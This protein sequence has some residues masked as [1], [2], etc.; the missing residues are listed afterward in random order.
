MAR[1]TR[2]WMLSLI[3]LLV[4]TAITY[5]FWPKPMKVDIGQ[6]VQKPMLISIDEEAKTR[7]REAYVVSTP[8]AGRLLRVDIEPGDIVIGNQSVVARMLPTNPSA[9]DV[10]TT[11]QAN[12]A[13]SA[14][15]AALRLARADLNK[16]MIDR[17]LVEQE[18]ER[19]K[20]LFES[21]VI[22]QVALD[23]AAQNL[24]ASVA[25]LN[26]AQASISMREAD[27]TNNR[28]L[29]MSFNDFSNPKDTPTSDQPTIP[30]TAPISGRVLRLM[31]LSEITLPAGAPILEIGDVNEGLEIVAELLSTDAVKINVGNRVIIDNWGGDKALSGSVERIDPWGYTKYSALG[32]EEQRVKIVIQFDAPIEQDIN[33]GHGFR[34][35]V[36]IVIW[37][38]EQVLTLPSSAL[39][40]EG[41]D[42]A[43][44][45]IID[46]VA[47]KG[48]VKIGYN[49]GSDAQLL[50]GLKLD[51]KV[52]L[53]PS[54]ALV[55][56]QTVEQRLVE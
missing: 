54:S 53:Y 23:R 2:S 30:I 51:D 18:V 17:D 15:E 1:K 49:N 34:V 29:L 31:Q 6:V 22:S 45:K 40:R 3:A 46:G 24:R 44:F 43:V 26:S 48:L 5:S 12:A 9:L 35:E 55:D 21:G 4:I 7:V 52:I 41:R 8:I 50:E 32:V 37:Q 36:K 19:S 27:L 14:A 39:F 13:V 47:S 20:R 56:G 33:L 25:I 38:D 42:W 16:A 10:R 11:E 28:A